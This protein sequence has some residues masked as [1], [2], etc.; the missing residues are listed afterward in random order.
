VDCGG[1]VS[2][3]ILGK[4]FFELFL[5]CVAYPFFQN[6]PV[7]VKQ[8]D[9]GLVVKAECLLKV[10]RARVICIEVRELYFSEIF[11]FEPMNHGR[12]GAAGTSG[13]AEEFHKLE[14]PGSQAHGRRIGSMEIRPA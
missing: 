9:F 4:H 14:L 8:V 7:S 1:F 10:E 11:C 12:H 2:L 3:Q 5:A 13:E 6:I